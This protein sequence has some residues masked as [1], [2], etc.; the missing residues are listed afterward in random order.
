M[1]KKNNNTRKISLKEKIV[2]RFD[3][4]M[5]K[6][7][8]SLVGILFAITLLVVIIAG[9]LSVVFDG[10]SSS[11]LL[12]GIWVSLMHAIDAG[13]LT[14]DAGSFP[15]MLLMTIVTICGLFITSIL[16]GI[17]NTGIEGKMSNLRKGKSCVLESGHT[18]ILGFNQN[19]F[20]ILSELIEANSNQKEGVV[21]IMDPDMEKEEMEDSIRQRIPDTKSTRII[22]RNGNISDFS[23]LHVCSPEYAKSIIINSTDDF[24][25]IKAIL[26]TTNLLKKNIHSTAYIVGV[27]QHEENYEAALIAGEG[28]AEV[29]FF[30]DTIARIIAHTCRQPGLSSVF[31]ELFN[32]NGDEIYIEEIPQLINKKMCDLNLYLESTTVLG[33]E[34]NGVS[35]LAPPGETLV[36]PGDKLIILAADDGATVVSQIKGNKDESCINKLHC[37]TPE[38]KQNMLILGYGPRLEKVLLEED[39][40]MAK[41]SE[42]LLAIQQEYEEEIALLATTTFKNISVDI[43]ICDIYNKNEL[44]KLLARKPESVLVPTS[45]IDDA[46]Y[47]DSKTLLLL[48]QLRAL[49][50]ECHMKHTVTTEMRNVQNQELAQVTEVKDFVVSSKITSLMV[51]QI[52][53]SRKLRGIFHELLTSDGAEIYIRPASDYVTLGV[54]LTMYT[55][56]AACTYKDQVFL[57]YRRS[58]PDCNSFNI[59]T[60][61]NKNDK[62]TFTENDSLIVLSHN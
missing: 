54:P 50:K 27:I 16:I 56:C 35:Y 59:V 55:A 7:T 33:I 46:Q 17:I 4:L 25:T 15:F 31:T 8:I 24:V 38:K 23:D 21:V 22:C 48:L 36:D 52:S 26:A 9:I 2:Y 37:N 41:G 13:T 5:A 28:R 18:I 34:K 19:T 12:G 3:N 49:S 51:T 29:L 57:G 62:I 40:Y 39:Q 61:P 44:K 14:A 47:D 53:Q 10:K 45:L 43:R 1:S 58:Y 20:T 60:N 32:Y 30:E 11:S 6:G 42:I